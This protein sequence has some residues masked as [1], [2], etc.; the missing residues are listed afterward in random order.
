MKAIQAKYYVLTAVLLV[1]MLLGLFFARSY[2]KSYLRHD[3]APAD[4]PVIAVFNK[5]MQPNAI[6]MAHYKVVWKNAATWSDKSGLDSAIANNDILITIETWPTSKFDTDNV[7]V[8]VLKGAFN[9]KISQ[10]AALINKSDHQVY[11][12]YD[13]DMEVPASEFPWQFQSPD[14]YNRSFNYFA[15]KV[16]QQ[17]PKVKIVWGPSGYPGDTEYWPGN[18]WVDVAS[19]TLGSKSEKTTDAYPKA[20]SIPEMLRAKLHRL[21]FIDKPVLIIGS[22]TLSKTNFKM[23]WLVNEAA[24]MAKYSDVVYSPAN[25]ADTAK[26]KPSRDYLR[27][28]A[29][30][31]NK[32]LI[33]QKS[34]NV[35]HIFTDFGE[36]Q[37]GDFEK[38]FREII[39]RHHEAIVTME[40]W[41][42]TSGKADNNLSQNIVNGRYDEVIKKL[43]GIIATTQQTVYL[44]WMHEMEIP[45]HRYAWQS[46][47]PVAY[48]KAYRYFMQFEGGPAKNVKKVWGPA[49]DRGSIDF[50]PG[51]DVVDFISIAI[52]GLPD[53]NITD[54]KKQEPFSRI[55]NR[56]YFRMRFSDKP[57]F[58]TEFGVKGPESYQ[59]GWLAN[60]AKTIKA[61]PHVFGI[62]YFN[63]YDNPKAWGNIK[64]PDWSITPRSMN[65]FSGLL[66]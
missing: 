18:K 30:D 17:A 2:V 36:V 50:W 6:A 23:Q 28:G 41:R 21:R 4:E 44:R 57:I 25:Y 19:I 63:L 40:P 1:V 54:P 7:L 24:Y 62:C 61:N 48:I 65:K 46:Q 27:L 39:N 43:F 13:P 26:T 15:Q 14:T 37:R 16:K 5:I 52:Y 55:F 59:D 38:K 32:R 47:D 22:D 33:G 45:I 51:D 64:A 10:L 31:L 35:E 3:Y 9:G 56:K 42:D 60:A 49:G 53:K 29:F 20:K 58:I 34:I 11:V 66:K 8:E 12:R